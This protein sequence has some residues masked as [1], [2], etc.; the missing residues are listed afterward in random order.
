MPRLLLL[1]AALLAALLAPGCGY[2]TYNIPSAELQR[3]AQLPPSQRGNHIRVYTPGLV[4]AATPDLVPAAIPNSPMPSAL[5][6]PPSPTLP[7]LPQSDTGMS[8]ELAKEPAPVVDVATP[9]VEP[10]NPTLVVAVDGAPPPFAPLPAPAP[11]TH[12]PARLPP[13]AVALP[14]QAPNIRPPSS[15]S[16]T[17]APSTHV[18]G[19]HRGT[20]SGPRAFGGRGGGGGGSVAVG[21]AVGAVALIGLVAI[22]ADANTKAPFDGWVRTSS[23]H[24]LIISYWSGW[25]REVC[26]CDLKPTDLVGMQS[27]VMYDTAGAIEELEAAGSNPWPVQPTQRSRPAARPPAPNNS[28]NMPRAPPSKPLAAPPAASYSDPF[29]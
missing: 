7:A 8:G 17:H 22:L 28:P 2:N 29:S 12:P 26:L 14:R 18:T 5:P 15:A 21:A 6:P 24:P 27:A 16:R 20:S 4:P 9:G 13:P 3:L 11:R 25:E 10:A 19:G 23:D 1:L